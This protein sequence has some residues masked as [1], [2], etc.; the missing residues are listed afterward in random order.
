MVRGRIGRT[1]PDG[2]FEREEPSLDLV[3]C[4][5]LE[6]SEELERLLQGSL[7]LEEL[8]AERVRIDDRSRDFLLFD[9]F[10]S[11]CERTTLASSS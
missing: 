9:V 5:L 1:S 4:G 6:R 2:D 3:A 11:G 7:G 8:V 10:F